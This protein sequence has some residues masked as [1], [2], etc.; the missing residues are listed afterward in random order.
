[1][2]SHIVPKS[3]TAPL[4]KRKGEPQKAF[5]LDH[6]GVKRHTRR[7]GVYQEFFLCTECEG[8]LGNWDN[9]AGGIFLRHASRW[10]PVCNPTIWTPHGEPGE[11]RGWQVEADAETIL[12]FFASFLW[13]AHATSLKE[14]GD[15]DLGEQAERFRRISVA[16]VMAADSPLEA[17]LVRYEP[18]IRTPGIEKAWSLSPV[19]NLN[20]RRCCSFAIGGWLAYLNVDAKPFAPEI[21]VGML[22]P[23]H[24][25]LAISLPFD[26][27]QADL[28]L[29]RAVTDIHS[30]LVE[31]AVRGATNKIQRAADA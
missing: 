30:A 14:F 18:S 19:G 25:L 3:F 21:Q 1:M 13:R 15:F 22:K 28:A 26:G 10:Q 5:L 29:R 12:L 20:G 8:R 4:N 23:N 17:V 24:P 7:G 27:S 31:Q 6:R 16:G 9:Y 11:L 2:R